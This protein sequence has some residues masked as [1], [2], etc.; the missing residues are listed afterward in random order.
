M[1]GI[2][3][4]RE[5]LVDF[6]ASFDVASPVL[7]YRSFTATGEARPDMLLSHNSFPP[8]CPHS[9]YTSHRTMSQ[10]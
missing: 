9:S 5:A 6:R 2:L 10:D 7:R 8:G 4:I 3:G 1:M